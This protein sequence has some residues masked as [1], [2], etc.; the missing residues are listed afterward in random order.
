[1]EHHP[2]VQHGCLATSMTRLAAYLYSQ[3]VVHARMRTPDAHE[4]TVG[5]GLLLT[6]SAASHT[7]LA[8]RAPEGRHRCWATTGADLTLSSSVH[9]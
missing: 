5:R 1:M 7:E 4:D 3:D 9:Q 8:D 2:D 6:T